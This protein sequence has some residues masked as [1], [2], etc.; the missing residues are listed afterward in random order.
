MAKL[1][2]IKVGNILQPNTRRQKKSLLTVEL[3]RKYQMGVIGAVIVAKEI[4]E[5]KDDKKKKK[6]AEAAKPEKKK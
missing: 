3:R 5:R 4:E 6:N 1:N 2:I